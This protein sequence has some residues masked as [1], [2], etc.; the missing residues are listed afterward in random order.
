[1]PNIII[2]E[3]PFNLQSNIKEYDFTAPSTIADFLSANKISFKLPT[4]C[5]F[6]GEALLRSEWGLKSIEQN[7]CVSFISL[8]QGGG[9]GSSKILRTVMTIAIMA[10]A[11]YAS[12]PLAGQLGITSAIG[13]SLLTAGIALSG[14]VLV[15]A[16]I[17]PPSTTASFKTSDQP[18]PTYSLA[19][20][21]N[22]ARLGEPIPVIYGRH[23]V[24]P[25]F[26]A[27]PYTE[28]IDNEQ[29]LFQLHT[30][31][32]G[33][34]TL[35]QIRI[36]D[37]PISSFKEIEYE[38]IPPSGQV[39]LLNTNVVIASEVAGQEIVYEDYIGPFTANPSETETNEL[40][41]DIVLPKGLY[42]SNDAGGLDNRTVTWIIEARK[43]DDE[44]EALGIWQQLGSETITAATNSAIRKTYKYAIATGRYEVRAKRTNAKDTSIR[45]GD[46]INWSEL[47]AKL[48]TEQNFG[49]VTLLALKMLATDNLSQRSSR[50]VNCIVTRKL[51]SWNPATG[52]QNIQ[53]TNSIAWALA[54]ILKADYGAK[55]NDARIDLV[56]LYALD[57][58]WQQRGDEFNGV[59]DSKLT[60]WDALTQTARCGRAIPFMQGGI[61]RFAR[62]EI[63]TLPVAMFSTRNIVKGSFN[64]QY[65]MPG[66]DTADSVKVEF[67][68]S[69]TW[70]TDEVT[71]SL[72]D[73]SAD[74]PA[75]VALFGCTNKDQA[76]REGLYMSAANRYRRRIVSFKTELEGMIPTYGDLIAISHDMPSWGISGEI[77]SYNH[78]NLKLS[79]Q[80]EFSDSANHFIVFRRRDGSISG[81]WQVTVGNSSYEVIL[82]GT[83]D[84]VPYTGSSEERT[85]FSF[86]KSEEWGILARVTSV[87]PQGELVE[88][89]AVVENNLVHSAD[90][91]T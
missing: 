43:I 52:W 3:N 41:I 30:I 28:Y 6:N 10:A 59:F 61:V 22:T 81:P 44:G 12:G 13:K 53:E 40:A 7:D 27:A 60:V 24:Y 42:Y 16:L 11:P 78:P 83:L 23:V 66:E 32:Q 80:V 72:P 65:I 49:N 51:K 37:T 29:Y 64:I 1:M 5:L 74:Q 46:D 71:A 58:I 33:E 36:E 62:D 73:S 31:G 26:A 48:I 47:K 69:R 20:Q 18:S 84:F 25:D 87:K 85:H 56:S 35:E 17:P 77:T 68:N 90:N 2:H 50:L 45:A 54:D 57:N 88:I 19:A 67:F 39:S 21:G 55:L 79:E 4:I 8:P 15:N 34:Y 38:I 86:G 76:L 9:G 63:K 75:T 82:S 89:T 91:Y 70:K 14:S